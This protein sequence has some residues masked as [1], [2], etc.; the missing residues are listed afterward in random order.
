MRTIARSF[1]L[2]FAALALVACH[3]GAHRQAPG[4]EAKTTLE[5]QNQGFLDMDI[6]VLRSGQRIRIGDVSGNSTTTLT[7]P[8]YLLS[9]PTPLRFL[10]DPVGGV[11]TPV[12]QEI[13]VSPGDEVTLIIPP[14]RP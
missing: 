5:V 3:H 1:V 9:G 11:R 10:A 4:R 8:S 7:I 12:S 14:G 6:F 13:T 2:G